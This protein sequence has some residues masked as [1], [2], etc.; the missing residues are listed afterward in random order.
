MA[1]GHQEI[2][3]RRQAVLIRLRS[4]QLS[5]QGLGSDIEQCPDE[6]AC[7]G[8]TLF[9]RRVGVGRDAEI[10]QLHAARIRIIHQVV[11]LQVAMN[12]AHLVGRLDRF[13]DLGDDFR[14]FIERKRA[15]PLRVFLEELTLGPLDGEEVHSRC[16]FAD[17]QRADDIRMLH[18][19]AVSS[20]AKE[21]RDGGLVATEFLA[22]DLHGDGAVRRVL[23]AKHGRRSTFADFA[24]KGVAR[25]SLPDQIL[26]RHG[27]NLTAVKTGGKQHMCSS[28]KGPAALIVRWI[29]A[30]LLAA[31]SS[32][33]VNPAPPAAP[34]TLAEAAV[35]ENVDLY[36]AAGFIVGTGGIPFVGLVRYAATEFPDSTI[37]V[38]ALSVPPRSLSFV[39]AGD[40]YAAFYTMRLDVLRGD[41]IVRSERPAGE[42][43][44]ASFAETTRG[45]EGIL[46]QR[47]LRAAPGTYALRV[48]AQD[49]LGTG[50]GTATMTIVVPPLREGSVA[51][52]VPVFMAD[53]RKSRGAPLTMIVNP[54]ATARY[55]RDS[56]LEL[57]VESYGVSA[58]DT[59][60]I[61]AR[62]GTDDELLMADTLPLT[63]SG[64]VRA[65]SVRLPVYRLGLGPLRLYLSS[66]KDVV[67]DSLT[68]VVN[69]GVDLPVNSVSELIESMRYFTSE[70]DVQRMRA[71]SPGARP[72]QWSALVRRT[73]P[74][75][76]T[77]DNEALLEY[78]RRLRVAERLYK[79]G[80]RHGWQ[81]DR[82]AAVAALGEP[83]YMTQPQPADTIGTAKVVTWEYRRHRLF[84]VFNDADGPGMWRFTPSSAEL[85]RNLIAAA[86]PCVGCR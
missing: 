19:L 39:R 49:S 4:D 22:K 73:D 52:M 34:V 54:R 62:G 68:G 13:A 3:D 85:F 45:D 51:P 40:R 48:T 30:A 31:C 26:S 33:A 12:D 60:M 43:R 11:R 78:A 64:A 50:T 67:V 8:E 56:T 28:L 10:E 23:G 46:F 32:P 57:Y 6:E 37:V 83:D 21:S 16:A 7:A 35:P 25:D 27:A 59:L 84:L 71:A 86:G 82:G 24:F 20:L 5:R 29:G 53:P 9:L 70:T 44:V 74:N 41:A 38:V 36:R 1:A 61:V 58:A 76:A 55:G 17:L 14:D 81:T 65:G 15:A 69:L 77:P 79:Q 75:T 72:A 80:T 18:A 42:V 47:T 66:L 63:T 2:G